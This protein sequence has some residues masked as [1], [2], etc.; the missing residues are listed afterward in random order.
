MGGEKQK[1]V[2][3]VDKLDLI[4]PIINCQLDE[5]HH[6]LVV[7]LAAFLGVLQRRIFC[8]APLFR[9]RTAPTHTYPF[10][11]LDTGGAAD[12]LL[13]TSLSAV[14]LDFTPLNGFLG[15]V[16]KQGRV[17]LPITSCHVY[18]CL[19]FF[20]CLFTQTSSTTSLRMG[21]PNIVR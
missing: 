10:S 1:G 9:E 19:Y 20:F 4:H 18:D 2:E 6:G 16:P 13:S 5:V 11:S 3:D 7:L 17:V 14:M 21:C 12:P 15:S 8:T